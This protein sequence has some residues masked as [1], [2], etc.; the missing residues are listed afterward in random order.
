MKVTHT[1]P[2][3]IT[4]I[5]K[6][7]QFDDCLFFSTD[8]YSMTS[9]GDLYVYSLELAA[10]KIIEVGELYNED[11]IANIVSALDV[12]EDAA[13][14]ML[15]GRDNAFNHG[16][17]GSDDWWIQAKQGECA[18][19]MGYEAVEAQDEQGTVYIVPMSNR[20]NDL[21]LERIDAA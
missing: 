18:K 8:E 20:E 2:S 12:D 9:K 21:V 19:L 11:V 6:H 7:G 10:D 4:K 14:R 16:L 15:D 5:T 13:E 3:K 1:S 17:E